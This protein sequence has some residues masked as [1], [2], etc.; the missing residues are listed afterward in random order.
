VDL[1]AGLN[2]A[3]AAM[4]NYAAVVARAADWLPRP[5]ALCGWSMG[6]LAAMLAARVTAAELLVVLEPSPPAEIQGFDPRVEPR[7]GTF[8]PEETYGPFPGGVAARPD[9]RLARDERKRGV[10]VPSLD[11]PN[12][13]VFGDEYADER[14]RP[15]A[16]SY[17]GEELYVPGVDHWGL[18]LDPRVADAVVAWLW[19]SAGS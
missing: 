19:R 8:D 12:L 7:S 1:Q 9:S 2:V 18:V 3:Q 10:S 15:V 14:G 5:L 13:V 11:C 16:R 17:G 4:S 6:G